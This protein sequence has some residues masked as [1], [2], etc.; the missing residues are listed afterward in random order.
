MTTHVFI[1]DL[2]VMQIKLHS[3]FRQFRFTRHTTKF[4][5]EYELLKND[6]SRNF[7]SFYHGGISI[8]LFDFYA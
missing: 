6:G 5:V 4:T 7:S 3:L 2:Q 8:I 1:L